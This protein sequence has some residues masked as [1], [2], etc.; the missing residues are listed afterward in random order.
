[1]ALGPILGG[2]LIDRF[3]ITEGIRIS[4]VIAFL[5]GVLS[6]IVQQYTLKRDDPHKDGVAVYVSLFRFP[7]GLRR[8][9]ISDILVRF[10]EQMPYAYIAIWAVSTKGGA[11]ITASQF[12]VL[13]AVEMLVA[14]LVYIPVAYF[15]DRMRKKP[16]IVITYIF[17]TLFPLLLWLSTSFEVLVIAF[18]V[19][20]LKEF[21]EPTR[22]SLIMD[23]S[24][25]GQKPV[26]FGSYYFYRDVIVT[27]SAIVGAFLW[28]NTTPEVTFLTSFG[29]GVTGV[30][31]FAV[32]GKDQYNSN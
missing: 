24:P 20:G 2:V 12:G 26:Y 18:I 8:L 25:N 27:A 11:G 28:K 16:F 32:W 21:G 10:S 29:F 17:F 1:M 9:L 23:L 30:I 19:R 15:A 4:F 31:V 3:G 22:K 13:T 6:T 7:S 14:L 5:L